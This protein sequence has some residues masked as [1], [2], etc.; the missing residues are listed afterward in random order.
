MLRGA[1]DYYDGLSVGGWLY[2]PDVPLRDRTVLAFVDAA[3]VGA[4]KV[5]GFR[6]DLADAGL[7]DGYCGFNFV[8]SLAEPDDAARIHVKLEGSDFM[9]IQRGARVVDPKAQ[10]ASGAHA[11]RHDY[12]PES[13]AWMRDQ[14]WLDQTGYDFLRHVSTVGLYDRT[15]R[16]VG[17]EWLDPAAEAKRLFELYRQGPVRVQEALI[18]LR[19]LTQERERLVEGAAI[20]IVAIHADDGAVRLLEGS[21]G[22]KRAADL[23]GATRHACRADRILLLDTRATFSGDTDDTARVFRA[24]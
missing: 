9:L 8:V 5:D 20:P 1:I 14:N 17:T 18:Q 15:L 3:C 4:G 19:N 2:A 7:G 16:T 13:I 22:D 10:P 21:R 23:S 11:D 24:V 6:Q 12:S